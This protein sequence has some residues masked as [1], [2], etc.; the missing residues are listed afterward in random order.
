MTMTPTLVA[1]R[2]ALPPK[3]VNFPWDG[4]AENCVPRFS[5][6]VLTNKD[7]CND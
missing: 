3:G 6:R 7:C 4:P 5:L 1:S 2:T